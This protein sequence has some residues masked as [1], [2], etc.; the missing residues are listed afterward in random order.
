MYK[1]I[2]GDSDGP[3][4]I[5]GLGE[6][7]CGGEDLRDHESSGVEVGPRVGIMAI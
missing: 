6:L 4:I 5:D 2:R 7:D 3:V 1:M